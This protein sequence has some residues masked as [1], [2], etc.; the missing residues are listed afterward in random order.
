MS[1]PKN[2]YFIEI[3]HALLK[4][5]GYIERSK[6]AELWEKYED[7]EVQEMLENMGK[8][9]C[10]EIIPA[11][12]RLYM[13]PTQNNDIF[14]KKNVDFRSDIKA[15][16][17]VF[18][19]DLY[20]M[21]FLA[22]YILLLFYNGQQDDIR[23]RNF[24]TREQI[25]KEF[26]DF[27]NKVTKTDYSNHKELEYSDPFTMLVQD[28][29]GKKEGGL[30]STKVED[31][32]GVINKLLIKFDK[33]ELF[34]KFDDGRIVPTQKLDDL[35]PY[36]LQKDRVQVVNSLIGEMINAED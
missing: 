36:V 23:T 19:K 7:P 31:R 9:E 26:T 35:M 33:E 18:K 6:N 21:N 22:T 14:N 1:D 27:C 10:F 28:W 3:Y 4:G 13:V 34:E 8:I 11:H 30:N 12:N 16:N 17:E 5:G 20:L 32:Y 25:A 2:M 29:L 15:S 24:I